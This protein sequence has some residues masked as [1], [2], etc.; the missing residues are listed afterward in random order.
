M[1]RTGANTAQG[2]LVRSLPEPTASLPHFN[3]DAVKYI[4]SLLL[5]AVACFIWALITLRSP[6]I[7]AGDARMPILAQEQS[8]LWAPCE[9][10]EST[11]GLSKLT[12]RVT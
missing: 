8:T 2:Q 4:G 11:L 12:A 9:H 5:G 6:H 3:A 7:P 1:C 10:P